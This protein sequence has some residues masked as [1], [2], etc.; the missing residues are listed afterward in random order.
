[1]KEIAQKIVFYKNRLVEEPGNV[2]LK[3]EIFSL[4]SKIG[5]RDA[6]A[7]YGNI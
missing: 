2:K 3:Q 6:A 5:N 1:M 4:Y 7:K